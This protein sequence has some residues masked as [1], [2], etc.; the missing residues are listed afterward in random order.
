MGADTKTIQIRGVPLRVHKALRRQAGAEEMSLS[1]YC[2]AELTLISKRMAL[3]EVLQ[4]AGARPG[5]TTTA[6]VVEA[7]R[8]T[9][10][11][12]GA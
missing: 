4:R 10:D 12:N 7:V 8:R 9:R 2:L 6:S 5:G 11:T 1:D 3:A